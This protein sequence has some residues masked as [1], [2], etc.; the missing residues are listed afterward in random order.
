MLTHKVLIKPSIRDNVDKPTSH[1]N[2]ENHREHS[3]M[4]PRSSV[5]F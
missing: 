5:S 1:D 4:E 2:H 3:G